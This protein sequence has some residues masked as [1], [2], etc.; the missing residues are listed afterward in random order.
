[1]Y[2]DTKK[3]CQLDE[4]LGTQVLG[5]VV[6]WIKSCRPVIP[7]DTRVSPKSKPNPEWDV[8][9]EGVIAPG[10]EQ[11]DSHRRVLAEP[12]RDDASSRAAADDDVVVMRQQVLRLERGDTD[13][14]VVEAPDDQG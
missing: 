10:L 2:L 1:M 4:I 9:V 5:S 12:T 8:R 7:V 6:S 11:Q 14:L 3:C 13:G